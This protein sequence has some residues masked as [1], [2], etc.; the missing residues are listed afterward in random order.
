MTPPVYCTATFHYLGDDAAEPIVAVDQPVLDGR[1]APD[2]ALP[3]DECGFRLI[4]DRSSVSD[5]SDADEVNDRGA[6]EFADL[7]EQFTGCDLAVVLNV[8]LRNTAEAERVA[9]HAPILLVH[10]DYT[11]DYRAMV[12]EDGRS[13]QPYLQRELARYDV[14]QEV[15]RSASRLMVLQSWRNV[16]P[17]RPDHPL[18]FC[19]A[20]D[21]G[22]ERCVPFLIEEYGGVRA[23]FY[24]YGFRPPEARAD[25]W[26]TFPSMGADEAVLLRTYDSACA[27]TGR[28]F[29]TPHSA[30]RDPGVE[31][32]ADTHRSSTE[33][34]ALCIWH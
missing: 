23:A 14:D 28:R 1:A 21:A 15:L 27:D 8:I 13:Y 19:D 24:T 9:D 12:T 3:F 30:F 17:R 34:R 2:G 16:G 5:W 20:R 32:S 7:A 29:W 26:Y 10:S 33:L 25:H 31:A 18:A 11:D 4:Q 22:P 6:A